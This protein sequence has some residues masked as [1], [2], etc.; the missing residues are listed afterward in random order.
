[1]RLIFQYTRKPQLWVLERDPVLLFMKQ[2]LDLVLWKALVKYRLQSAVRGDLYLCLRM[3]LQ[4]LNKVQGCDFRDYR[5]ESQFN[6]REVYSGRKN[7]NVLSIQM[8]F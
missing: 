5:F 3:T 4:L 8:D 2:S 6:L 1:V 7:F